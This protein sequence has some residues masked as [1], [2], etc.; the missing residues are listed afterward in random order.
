VLAFR[1]DACRSKDLLK[2]CLLYTSHGSGLRLSSLLCTSLLPLPRCI[3][4][5]DILERSIE[6]RRYVVYPPEGPAPPKMRDLKT[7]EEGKRLPG[8]KEKRDGK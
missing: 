5:L 4:L 3:S 6:N 1:Y 8:S 7:L 2:L